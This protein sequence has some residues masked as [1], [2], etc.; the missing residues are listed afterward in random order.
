MGD[1]RA[2]LVLPVEDTGLLLTPLSKGN[3][4]CVSPDTILSWVKGNLVSLVSLANT[5]FF[6][7]H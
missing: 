1:F 7:S 6:G 5:P 2:P 4:I 3:E